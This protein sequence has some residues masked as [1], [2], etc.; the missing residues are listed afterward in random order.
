[1][2]L[3][4]LACRLLMIACWLGLA[5]EVGLLCLLHSVLYVCKPVLLLCLAFVPVPP[6][7]VPGKPSLWLCP[8]RIEVPDALHVVLHNERL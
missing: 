7:Q 4:M 8:S 6:P 5:L 1:M 2:M 3:M